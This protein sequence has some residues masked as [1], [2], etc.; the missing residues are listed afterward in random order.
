MQIFFNRVL[1]FMIIL[2]FLIQSNYSKSSDKATFTGDIVINEFMAGTS[3]RLIQWG[4]VDNSDDEEIVAWNDVDFNDSAWSEGAGGFGY[5][6]GDDTTIV[7][8]QNIAY[9]VYIRQ[10]FTPSAEDLANEN[11]LQ[12]TVTYDDGFV[13]YLNG[14]EIARRNLGTPGNFVPYT[15][16][17]DTYVEPIPTGEIITLQAASSILIEGDNVLAIQV[18]NSTIDSTDLSMIADLSITGTTPKTLVNHSDQWKYIIGYSEP[19]PVS[20]AT[21]EKAKLGTGYAW[22]DFEF[23]DSS[24]NSGIG[25]FGTGYSG[26]GTDLTSKMV[27]I[28]PSLYL[29][30][31]FIVSE[32]QAE[33]LDTLYFQMDYDDGFVA[34]LNGVEIKRKS[35]GGIGGFV[36]HDQYVYFGH[37]STGY[38]TYSLGSAKDY[39]VSGTNLLCIQAHN[40]ALDGGFFA[41]AQLYM[42]GTTTTN[43]VNYNDSWKYFAGKYEPSGVLVDEDGE[44]SDWIELYNRGDSTVS[45]NG[46]ALS[47]DPLVPQKW[48]L[49][50]ISLTSHSYLLIF[51]SGKDKKGT[52]LHTNFKLNAKGEYLSLINNSGEYQCEFSPEYPKQSYF[53]SFG[54]NSDQTEYVYFDFPTPVDD[55]DEGNLFIDILPT[56]DLSVE[57]GFYT[58]AFPLEMT[59]E[60]TD[61]EIIYTTNGT[62]PTVN[63]GITYTAPI[64]I[65]QTTVIKA[66]AIKTDHIYSNMATATYIFNQPDVV[67]NMRAISIVSDSGKNLYNPHGI[68][69]MVG[70]SWPDNVDEY[71]N[72]V[73]K[74]DAYERPVSIELIDINGEEGF[75]IDSGLR[76]AGSDYSRPLFTQSSKVS[77]K[78]YIR[79]EYGQSPL[80]YPLFSN[81]NVGEFYN[82]T[83]RGGFSGSAY[84]TYVEDEIVRR[85]LI[86]MGNVGSHGVYAN[87]FLNGTYKGWYNVCERMDEDFFRSYYNSEYDW[88]VIKMNNEILEGDMT[89]WS[90][91]FS[92]FSSHNLSNY[93]YYQT[94]CQEHVDVDNFINY[95]LV[96]IYAGNIDWPNNNWYAARERSDQGRFGFYAWD[97]DSSMGCGWLGID[98]E[99]NGDNF[100][101][102]DAW[103]PSGG[104]GL[105]GEVDAPAAKVY[106]ALKKSPEF[107]LAFADK[108]QKHFYNNGALVDENIMATAVQTT[109]EVKDVIQYYNGY[110]SNQIIDSFIP[111]RR[112]VVLNQFVREGLWPSTKAPNYNYVSGSVNYGDQLTMTNPNTGGTIYF[113]TDGSDPRVPNTGAVSSSASSYSS[114]LTITATTT[115]KARVKNGSSWSPLN[116]VVLKVGYNAG[117][118]IIT[119]FLANPNGDDLGKE[120]IELY[121]TT[122]NE[123][124]LNG[125][126]IKDND[127][128]THVINSGDPLIISA[129]G[130][131]VLG[132]SQDIYANGGLYVD[133][134]YGESFTLGNEGDEIILVQ[135]DQIIHSVGYGIFDSTPDTI[136]SDVE[137]TLTKGI[138]LG[139]VG[140]YC[141]GYSETWADQTTIYG[142]NGDTGTP[143]HTNEGSET[144]FSTLDTEP[145]YITEAKFVN[146]FS[147]LLKYNEP[148]TPAKAIIKSYYYADGSIMPISAI[149]LNES[150]V[151]LKFSSP[152]QTEIDHSI[153]SYYLTDLNGNRINTYSE[154]TINFSTP[155]VSISEIMYNNRA[156][157]I[158]WIELYNTTDSAIDISEWYI[159]NDSV[160]PTSTEGRITIPD[161]TI[162]PARKHIIVNLWNNPTFNTWWQMPPY[163]NIKNTTVL[164][165]DSLS[166]SGDTIALY[167]A[168][169]GG[170]LIDGSL[171]VQYPDLSIDGESI[172][173]I[174][175]SFGWTDD[176]EIV[177]LNF[178]AS[179]VPIGFATALNVDKQ[180]LADFAS[181]GRGNGTNVELSI[182]NWEL[183]D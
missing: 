182:F 73:M 123:I 166:N 109:N 9:S 51:A 11:N 172:E 121:N 52:S 161:G 47:D 27:G 115:V 177:N 39:L 154:A 93:S 125:S 3:D 95:L 92:Y 40:N 149:L 50:D 107:V 42:Q 32:E 164:N 108:I 6:D 49:P 54:L 162:I 129:K 132:E 36:Y 174:D 140:D 65:N 135:D 63:N 55:N 170:T 138:A 152:F 69:A 85:L 75:Q 173:K 175:D 68:M 90:A 165:S 157:D 71:D 56:P 113:T 134:A 119:E 160:Y 22:A 178:Q 91:M 112:S 14:Q 114:A 150:T 100:N 146:S 158:E 5:G 99:V 148:L 24:W 18:H 142:L 57:K 151:L 74:G 183:Y 110:Y 21:I 131:L 37:G 53:H 44:V 1:L 128:D 97:A 136:V 70:S 60:I 79:D 17:A 41:K 169:S 118:I 124:D 171:I 96:N 38:E 153:K 45:L 163:I 127:L 86:N 16:A 179:T 117:D 84:N 76:V 176:F 103:M 61:A 67:K 133:Y 25:P 58:S 145:P 137:T 98:A 8:I 83:F 144:C 87:L 167:N 122:D 106:R 4:K 19:S 80:K 23:N 31:I 64:Q 20:E 159:T 130:Y 180:T 120:W 116:E 102:Y 111:R 139:M 156:T 13:A 77:F 104:G 141:G 72:M 78:T 62:D 155:I 29:R 147:I 15:Q 12:F 59:C 101:D 94:A 181:P 28:T 88:D 2:S 34:Y 81:S 126:I 105:N 26:L 89:A 82:L 30:K 46:W 33:S 48:I 66:R 10:E 43:F 7:N 143:N 35:L 168:S